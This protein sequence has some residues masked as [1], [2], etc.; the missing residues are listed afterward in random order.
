MTKRVNLSEEAIQH[1]IER[2]RAGARP[3]KIAHDLGCSESMFYS[4]LDYHNVPRNYPHTRLYRRW[5]R[6]YRGP[7][8]RK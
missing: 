2:Y 7:K 4:I 1:A 6:L 3:P 5:G 8:R